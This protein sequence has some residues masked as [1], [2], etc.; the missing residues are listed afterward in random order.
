MAW[1][2]EDRTLPGRY[3]TA[4]EY[5]RREN[6]TAAKSILDNAETELDV[7]GKRRIQLILMKNLITLFETAANDG[8]SIAQLDSTELAELTAIAQHSSGG[9]A[10]VRAQS[11]LCFFY[12]ECIIPSVVPK[13]AATAQKKKPRI[14]SDLLNNQYGLSCY[15]NP[16]KDFVQVE[17]NLVGERGNYSLHLYD[18]LGRRLRSEPIGDQF[19]N[20]LVWD[21]RNLSSGVYFL[22]LTSEGRK[23]RTE[24]LIIQ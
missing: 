15:P 16:A 1:Y 13:N 24:K 21:T 12:D 20:M 4:T 8:R 9:Q 23:L 19:V 11:T 7:K 10:S 17:F 14:F 22:E 2:M 6:F 5:L 18:A 3:A